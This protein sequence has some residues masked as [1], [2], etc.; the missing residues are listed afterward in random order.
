MKV[1]RIEIKRLEKEWSGLVELTIYDNVTLQLLV[2]HTLKESLTNSKKL[3]LEF[4]L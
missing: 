2:K 3:Y 1:K 4:T